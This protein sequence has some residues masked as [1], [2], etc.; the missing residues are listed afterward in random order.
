MATRLFLTT[1]AFLYASTAAATTGARYPCT[2]VALLVTATKHRSIVHMHGAQLLQSK[3]ASVC[4]E[5]S[6]ACK[7]H[8]LAGQHGL[9]DASAKVRCWSERYFDPCTGS[10]QAMRLVRGRVMIV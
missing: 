6:D 2:R 4:Y 10:D 5:V 9:F 3:C 1:I 8:V 7:P